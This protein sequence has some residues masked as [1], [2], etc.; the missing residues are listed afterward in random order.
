MSKKIYVRFQITLH[1]AFCSYSH[2]V[3]K[4]HFNFGDRIFW[5]GLHHDTKLVLFHKIHDVS[6][7]EWRKANSG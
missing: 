1:G 4:P 5:G 7:K 6:H 3:S 2:N